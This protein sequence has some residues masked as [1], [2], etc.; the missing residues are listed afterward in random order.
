[1]RGGIAVGEGVRFAGEGIE[2]IAQGPI[3]SFDL[4][5][6]GCVDLG[7][8]R[9][10]DLHRQESP[11][12]I[13]MLDG[14]HQRDRLWDDPRRTPPFARSRR[15]SICSHQDAPIAV[16]AITEPVQ[17]AL[18]GPLDRARHR[19]L[20]QRFA[21]WTSGTGD[22]ETTLPILDQASPP[23]PFI[24]LGC[25]AFFSGRTTKTHRFPPGSGAARWPAPV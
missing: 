24:R 7:P 11:M 17:L 4:H 12:L 19:L 6:P 15:L 23:V 22:L 25:C 1:M 3:E 10:A 18:V 14:L 8:Q 21:H 16:P 9:G 2:P 5:R 20:D 13:T